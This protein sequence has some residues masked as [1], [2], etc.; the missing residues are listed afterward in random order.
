M[1][2]FTSIPTLLC[3][4]SAFCFPLSAFSSD[5]PQFRGIG[6]TGYSAEAKV[7]LKPK[8]DW[9]AEL[10]GRGLASPIIV[11]DNVF[12]T[13]SSGP[14]QERLH[15]ICFNAKDGSEVWE[16]QLKATGRTMSHPKTSVAACTP[17]SDGKR[18]FALWSSNDLAAFDLEGN[19]MWLRGLTVDYA[20]ASN[21][22]GMASSP[23]VIGETVVTMIENDS[24]SYTLGID[25]NTG[26][27]L[28]KMD[29]PKAANWCSPVVWQADKESAPVVVLQ[30]SKGL[31]GVDPATGSRLWEYT[32]GASTTS[33]SVVVGD[34]VYA[35]S[36]GITALKPSKTGA[37]PEQLW[38]SEQMSPSTISPVV[39]G[40]LI[41]T[42]NGAGVL[43]VA[44]I[45]TGDRGW[46]LRISD[47]KANGGFSGSPV[48]AG[49]HLVVATEKGLLQIVDTSAPE[50]AIVGSLQLPLKE[51]TKELVLCTPALSGNAIFLRTDS[52]LWR[53]GG[54]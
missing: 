46:K 38:R 54:E 22:L 4:I 2:T 12:V 16:R 8:I 6:S 14:K 23:I 29:R 49:K 35:A 43:S 47:V 53:V 44:D 52:A 18:V 37:E 39:I 34:I 42:I 13:C 48:G 5:W 45:K 9:T 36:K 41:L 17:C 1:K 30:S 3:T 10:P 28:W 7:P 21:S 51:S 19:L 26:R 27:N 24:E 20:N 33:S 31:V 25:A 11:G 40:N 50:G 15:V 32:D